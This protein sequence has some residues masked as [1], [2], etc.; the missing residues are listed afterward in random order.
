MRHYEKSRYTGTQEAVFSDKTQ[1]STFHR[2]KSFL[3]PKTVQM[4]TNLWLDHEKPQKNDFSWVFA[5][6]LGLIDAHDGAD[7]ES[8]AGPILT[9]I[10]IINIR[11]F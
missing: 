7:P 8:P 9:F 11:N 4:H 5:M 2:F 6:I 1:K 3:R 10:Q